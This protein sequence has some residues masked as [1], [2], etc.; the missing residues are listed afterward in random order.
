MTRL[1]DDELRA[2]LAEGL[3]SWAIEGNAIERTFRFDTFPAA[4]GFV[5]R[6]AEE[7]EAAAHHPDLLIRYRRVTVTLSTH[8]EG[9]VTA[10]DVALARSI[11]ALAPRP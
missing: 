2:A 3:S 9:G 11:D 7:A 4:I 10:K 1:S 6:V 8:D 5:D